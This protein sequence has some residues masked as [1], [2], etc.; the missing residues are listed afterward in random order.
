MESSGHIGN[1]FF[2]VIHMIF[3]REIISM[4]E[5]QDYVGVQILQ[6]YVDGWDGDVQDN[7]WP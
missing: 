7:F 2:F 1:G 5:R 6:I 3:D 4:S